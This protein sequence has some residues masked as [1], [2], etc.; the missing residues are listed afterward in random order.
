MEKAQDAIKEEDA[1]RLM[2]RMM[3]NKFDFNDFLEQYRTINKMGALGNVMKMIPGMNKIDDKDLQDV[4]RK[5]DM[6]EKIIDV[7]RPPLPHPR[8]SSANLIHYAR[9]TS[10]P[11]CL[12][13]TFCPICSDPGRSR[14][15][16]TA[17]PAGTADGGGVMQCMTE[18]ERANPDKL[19]KS[20]KLKRRLARDSGRTQGEVAQLLTTFTQM[21]IQMKTMSK[22]MAASGGMGAIPPHSSSPPHMLSFCPLRAC[23][24]HLFCEP[25]CHPQ[26]SRS[27][28]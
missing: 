4:E 10:L 5:Y 15:R 27:A 2:R 19:A 18:E 20:A 13:L 24:M 7:R 26:A 16:H 23:S 6:F 14:S 3:S 28:D 22:M 9:A 11:T 21:R 17:P 1:A 8:C 25:P 12:R